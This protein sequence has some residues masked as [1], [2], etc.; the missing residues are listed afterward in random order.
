M[1]IIGM[2]KTL[3]FETGAMNTNLWE[4]MTFKQ[5]R[6]V[7]KVKKIIELTQKYNLHCCF[8]LVKNWRNLFS[9]N[10]HSYALSKTTQRFLNSISR[11]PLYTPVNSIKNRVYVSQLYSGS[12]KIN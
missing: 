12:I 2:Y 9:K 3:I 5:W 6:K 1:N 10:K 7:S 4:R 11:T 8:I